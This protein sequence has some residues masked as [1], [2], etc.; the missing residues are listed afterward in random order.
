MATTHSLDEFKNEARV[1][2][3]GL[4]P[5]AEATVVT[6]SG[7]LG[8]GKT[9]FAREMAAIFDVQENVASPTYV[10]EKIYAC[11]RGPFRKF[12][13]IDAYRLKDQQELLALGWDEIARTREN[14]IIVEW[15]E[16]VAGLIP[17]RAVRVSLTMREG[18]TRDVVVSYR[19]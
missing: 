9:T 10:I 5:G 17:E 12:I 14:I 19:M 16:H 6:L 11:G 18:E 2:A 8:A 15:P 3:K 7:E 1:L 4:L 13:H